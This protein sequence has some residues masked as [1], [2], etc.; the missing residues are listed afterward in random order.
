MTIPSYRL[1][2]NIESGSGF[3]PS[4]RNVIQEAIAGNEQRIAL[5]TKCRG[6]GDLSLGLQ[7]SEDP[8]GDFKAIYAMYVAHRG[9]LYPWRFRCN[10]DCTAEDEAFGT[11]NG[12]DTAF[13]LTM[14][15]DPSMILLNTPG[16]LSYVRDI[17]LVVG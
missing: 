10:Y 12:S 7:V 4:W 11:G 3:G 17:T 8:V 6:I 9:S 16:S 5:W 1:P 13:Q 2:E 15:Y 14:T